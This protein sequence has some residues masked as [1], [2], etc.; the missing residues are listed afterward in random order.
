V[1]AP[2]GLSDTARRLA[3]EITADIRIHGADRVEES[4]NYDEA[5]ARLSA[6][7]AEG[8]ALFTDRFG[9][10]RAS[11]EILEEELRLGLDP[12][13]PPPPLEERRKGGMA[14]FFLIGCAVV[15]AAGLGIYLFFH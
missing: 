4:G 2:G 9:S 10:E 8:R 11:Q 12:N 3:R 13:K 1:S 5:A 7:V 14:L 6:E 15:A